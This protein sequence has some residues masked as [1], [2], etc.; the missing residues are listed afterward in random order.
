MRSAATIRA[1][2][3][4]EDMSLSVRERGEGFL[5]LAVVDPAPVHSEPAEGFLRLSSTE[6]T[7]SHNERTEG[8]LAEAV[9]VPTLLQSERAEW[10]LAI[11][12][13]RRTRDGRAGRR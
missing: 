13:P 1:N 2:A 3:V 8:L 5:A 9:A 11:S 6:P 7:A 4:S 10:F 12:P